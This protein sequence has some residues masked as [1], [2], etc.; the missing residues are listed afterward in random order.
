MVYDVLY[1]LKSGIEGTLMPQVTLEDL[2]PKY[3][4][5]VSGHDIVTVE[6]ALHHGRS[7]DGPILVHVITEKGHDYMPAEKHITDR[8]HTVGPIRPET[9]LP[10]VSE[11]FG[12]TGI[13]ADEICVQIATCG[14]TV[15]ITVAIIRPVGLGLMR[16][17]Y[18]GRVVNVDIAG[19]GTVASAV[20]MAH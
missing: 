15:G 8:F 19:A 7:L 20:G 10:V 3:I 2:G 6:T 18:P 16:E 17:A 14:D 12:W 1:G 5:P 11:H 9:G 4:D 13:F